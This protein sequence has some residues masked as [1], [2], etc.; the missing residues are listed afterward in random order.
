M[1][2]ATEAGEDEHRKA[3]PA[4]SAFADPA[5]WSRL[6]KVGF[7]RSFWGF[8]AFAVVTGTACWLVL[9]EPAFVDALVTD[10]GLILRMMPRVG[11]ALALAGLLWVTLP[12]D[13]VTALI[14]HESGLRGLLIAT[15]AGIIT[16]GGPSS[17]FALLAVLGG[18][19]ADRGAMIAYIV[20]WAI[21]GVQRILV[22]DVP[23]MGADF[24]FVRFLVCLPLPFV[25]GLIAR[26]LPFNL[27]LVDSHR[28]H[29]R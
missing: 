6:L 25:T 1:T 3:E 8:F 21:L 29:G 16:P 27:R 18:A 22:W 11:L 24:S 2:T 4:R 20:S 10:V 5:W 14:G 12:R 15:G 17:A 19:G 23:F 28:E 7:G 9:G 13:R 26:R